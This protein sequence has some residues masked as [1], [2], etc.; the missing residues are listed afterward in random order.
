MLEDLLL[1]DF[2]TYY[3][4]TEIKTKWYWYKERHT[5][6]WDRNESPDV[7]PYISGQLIFDNSIRIIQWGRGNSTSNK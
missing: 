5:D 3:K 4:A 6:H 2:K 7:S 1:P